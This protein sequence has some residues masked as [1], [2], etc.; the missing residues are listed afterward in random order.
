MAIRFDTDEWIKEVSRQLN[1]SKDYEASAKDWEGDF[2][3][4]AEPDESYARPLYFFISLFHGKSPDAAM[5]ASEDERKAHYK[6]RGTFSTWRK[7][8]EGKLD[9][10]QGMMTKKLKL[11]GNLAKVMRYPRAAKEIVAACSKVPTDFGD[12]PQN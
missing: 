2:I 10:I 8:I 4:V 5:I 6:V 12:Q 11:D 1:E 7:V 9:P 3:F